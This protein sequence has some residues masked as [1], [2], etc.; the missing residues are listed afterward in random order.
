[1]AKNMDTTFL[2]R[3]DF[4]WCRSSLEIKIGFVE[5]FVGIENKGWPIIP[6]NYFAM[7]FL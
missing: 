6:L 3:I 1:M 7:E 4:C 5:M 2:D